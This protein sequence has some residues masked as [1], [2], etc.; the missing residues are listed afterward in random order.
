MSWRLFDCYHIFMTS[1]IALSRY[2]ICF[3][4]NIETNPQMNLAL[5]C[6]SVGDDLVV[7]NLSV[8]SRYT[9]YQ[10]IKFLDRFIYDYHISYD[11]VK[12]FENNKKKCVWKIQ[13]GLILILVL[14]ISINCLKVIAKHLAY[15]QVS[16][17]FSC[18]M[19]MLLSTPLA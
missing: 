8:N 11:M 10:P 7:S 6:K 18:C 2:K 3:Q 13:S 17:M 1:W 19:T 16:N 15:S 9:K 5:Q 4:N 14:G 12:L